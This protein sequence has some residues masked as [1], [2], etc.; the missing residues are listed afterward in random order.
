ML[1]HGGDDILEE[2]LAGQGVAVVDDRL[3]IWPIPAVNFKTAAAFPQS[4]G[5]Y[6]VY[7]QIHTQAKKDSHSDITPLHTLT[8]I[9]FW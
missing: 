5:T 7:T 6:N 2:Y 9:R 3:H 1:L 4:T 8:Q